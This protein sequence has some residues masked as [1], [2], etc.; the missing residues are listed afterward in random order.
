MRGFRS[1]VLSLVALAAGPLCAQDA[2]PPTIVHPGAQLAYTVS[3]RGGDALL[4]N[5]VVATLTTK[6][7]L[8]ADQAGFERSFKGPA[9]L[10]PPK[11]QALEFNVKIVVPE[12]AADGVYDVSFAAYGLDGNFKAVYDVTSGVTLPQVHVENS[13]SFSRPSIVVKRTK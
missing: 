5:S 8:R 12:F 10:A 4:Y 9:A 1:I 13:L 2:T 11:E 6:T 3:F 7:P